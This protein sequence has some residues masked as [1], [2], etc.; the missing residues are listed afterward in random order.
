MPPLTASTTVG[1][2]LGLKDFATLS[3]GEK[4]AA[5]RFYRK[6]E[7]ILHRAQRKLSRRVKGST[8]RGRAKTRVRKVHRKIANCRRD[9]LHKLSRRLVN[10]F[11]TICIEDLHVKGLAKTKLAKS[12]HD[13]AM[14][15]FRFLLRYK[16]EQSGK[17]LVVIG[18]LYPSTKLCGACGALNDTLTLK[19]RIWT[20]ECGVVH[21][22]DLNA[23]YNIAIEGLRCAGGHSEQPNAGGAGVSLLHRSNR[24]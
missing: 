5:P 1:V 9:F 13:A 23:A 20:C 2:D 21:D 7:R 18:R 12:M 17:R 10:E 6:S 3:T 11:D 16:A 14:G 22:R 24:R 19:D 4:I 15:L 8:G